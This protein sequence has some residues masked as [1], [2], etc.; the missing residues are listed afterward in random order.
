MSPSDPVFSVVTPSFNMLSYIERCHRSVMDQGRPVEHIVVDTVS[1]DGTSA[2][3][4]RTPDVR[5]IVAR[6]RGMYDAVNNGFHAA[7]GEFLSYL[8]C[9]EQ[10]L[11]GTLDA[12]E[13]A[14]RAQPDVDFLFGD[15]LLVRPDGELLAYRKGYRLSRSYVLTSHLY[16]L[17]CTLFLRRRI[18]ERE[19]DL[20]DIGWRAA[21]DAELVVRLLDRGYHAMHLSRYLSSFTMTGSNLGA[22]ATADAELGRFHALA[23]G[24]MR[25]LRLPIN[26][27]RLVEKA[28]RGV[29]FQ[30]FP[31][32]YALWD[33]DPVAR[34]RR[35]HVATRATWRWP[36]R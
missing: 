35:E 20:F 21:G 28:A 8:N 3:L 25:A 10:Y 30:T 27:L 1:T 11:P 9:D 16:V 19:G 33:S 15:A 31:L 22:S 29:Y 4:A 7:R 34:T 36:E 32:R 14:F 5:A 6:D 13:A 17:T 24:W 12:V 23:P 2:W 26:A 18:L